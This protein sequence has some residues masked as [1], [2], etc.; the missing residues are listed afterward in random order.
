MSKQK[1]IMEG[2]RDFLNKFTG[3]KEVDLEN[4]WILLIEKNY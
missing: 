3:S 2:W 4:L 1:L